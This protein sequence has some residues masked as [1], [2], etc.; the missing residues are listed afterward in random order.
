MRI[1]K[2]FKSKKAEINFHQ[3]YG[4]SGLEDVNKLIYGTLAGSIVFIILFFC[5]SYGLYSILT[6]EIGFTDPS[7]SF[8]E[9]LIKLYNYI[10]FYMILVLFIVVILLSRGIYLFSWKSKFFYFTYINK[11]LLGVLRF[12]LSMRKFFIARSKTF[13]SFAILNELI[14]RRIKLNI[15][16]TNNKRYIDLPWRKPSKEL[17]KL[18]RILDIYEYRRLEAVWCGLPT[19]ILL[20]I[21]GPSLAFIYTLDPSIDPIYTI[22]ILGRQWYWNYSFEGI[23]TVEDHN[24][25]LYKYTDSYKL[26]NDFFAKTSSPKYFYN[27]NIVKD[28]KEFMSK[29]PYVRRAIYVRYN[30]DSLMK[31]EDDLINGS[32]RLLEVDNRLVLPVGVPIRLVITSVDVIHSWAVPAL[33]IKVDAVPG[34]LSQFIVEIKKPGIYFGQCSELCGPL[35]GYMPIVISVVPAEEFEKW[36]LSVGE[37]FYKD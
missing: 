33:G 28:Y 5:F 23:I 32:H 1:Q 22:K 7:S 18:L 14:S 19:G 35:H 15:W 25:E 6:W 11:I 9:S 10:W 31:L 34:R 16:Y 27:G 30:F 8:A 17:E 29:L 20:S 36:L 4:R 21:A 24:S 2:F 12:I 13:R 26:L 3:Y 37:I